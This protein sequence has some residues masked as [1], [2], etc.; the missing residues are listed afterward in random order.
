MKQLRHGLWAA[1][2][3]LTACQFLGLEQPR[4]FSDRLLVGYATVTSVRQSAE[5]LLVAKAITVD[6]A[7]NVQQGADNARAGL[8]IAA[9]VESVDPKAA[10]ARLQA[11]MTILR[12][13]NAY[14][15]GRR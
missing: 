12:A 3:L 11:S 14:L 7:V 4:S 6:E 5:T 13:L 15:E 9:Q 8:D 10:D 1:I 2:L